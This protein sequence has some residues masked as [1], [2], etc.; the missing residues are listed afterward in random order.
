MPV[1]INEV[2]TDITPEPVPAIHA[3]APQGATPVTQPEYEL[4]QTLNL[5]QERQA[6]LQFD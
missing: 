3:Q 5:I 6:R 4:L 1:V 2:V